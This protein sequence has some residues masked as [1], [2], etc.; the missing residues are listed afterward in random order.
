MFFDLRGVIEQLNQCGVSLLH[1]LVDPVLREALELNAITDQGHLFTVPVPAAAPAPRNGQEP[2]GTHPI[3]AI[4]DRTRALE[5]SIAYGLLLGFMYPEDIRKIITGV[6]TAM[7]A[8]GAMYEAD[9]WD[10][11]MCLVDADSRGERL[12]KIFR[13]NRGECD[14]RFL[15]AFWALSENS[16]VL[17]GASALAV[18]VTVNESFVIGVEPLTFGEVTLNIGMPAPLISQRSLT[19]DGVNVTWQP[20][21]STVT[22]SPLGAGD[23]LAPPAPTRSSVHDSSP[24][25]APARTPTPAPTSK[26]PRSSL[27]GALTDSA[28]AAGPR[29]V[30][31]GVIQD[32]LLDKDD[33]WVT[34]NSKTIEMH[35]FEPS[36]ARSNFTSIF[37]TDSD[38]QDSVLPCTSAAQPA[39]SQPD[40]A[41]GLFERGSDLYE[42]M[43]DASGVA[44]ST[45]DALYDCVSS[46]N[47]DGVVLGPKPSVD[48]A[49][50]RLDGLL[51]DVG[52][53]VALNSCAVDDLPHFDSVKVTLVSRTAR[54]GMPVK[55][56]KRSPASRGLILHFHGGG[57]VS[58]TSKTHLGYLKA[59][60][61]DTDSPVLSVDYSLSPQHPYPRALHECF[62]VYL[63]A[64]S[65]SAR[66]GWS[67]QRICLT[68]DSA[69]GNLAVA[70]ALRAASEN[71]RSVP[72]LVCIFG[73]PAP[74]CFTDTIFFP[75][76]AVC[77]G[78]F[79]S[80]ITLTQR[81]IPDGIVIC[82]PALN[83]GTAL[84][85]SR[86]VR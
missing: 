50:D 8:Y 48:S 80:S 60:A 42:T 81:R 40:L 12:T 15:Q 82:Y 34:V 76:S 67:G 70:V 26:D 1:E 56:S 86:L 77:A 51:E 49:A 66:L 27:D 47:M 9:G 71:L 46:C 69:G 85:P 31:R 25:P 43:K 73:I 53:F 5:R 37:A 65:N 63:W 35:T 16:F 29:P 36:R 20:D 52:D 7:A 74:R 58:S 28:A 57:F 17:V 2:E 62:F 30:A 44:Q 54:E 22:V 33:E 55:S 3:A 61:K 41:C 39:R 11:G 59:W 13:K 68:G 19:S 10:A 38:G 18:P 6:A 45:W 64:I 24:A 75:L 14:P 78:E 4:F 79:T 83:V 21:P 72:W 23:E 32:V 84:S